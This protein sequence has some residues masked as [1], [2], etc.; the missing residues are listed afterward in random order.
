[1]K[2]VIL[3]LFS[4]GSN[5]V[6]LLIFES[7]LFISISACSFVNSASGPVAGSPVAGSSDTGSPVSCLIVVGTDPN[8]LAFPFDLVIAPVGSGGAG[9]AVFKIATGVIP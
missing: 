1:M 4:S 3:T 7:S 8:E 2:F 5:P 9:G 6:N